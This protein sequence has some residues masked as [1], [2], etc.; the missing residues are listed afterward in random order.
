MV[1]EADVDRATVAMNQWILVD[2]DRIG[3]LALWMR[4]EGLALGCFLSASTSQTLG[5]A[6]FAKVWEQI[7]ETPSRIT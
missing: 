6:Y 4:C 2:S 3:S 1:R 5:D 7:P